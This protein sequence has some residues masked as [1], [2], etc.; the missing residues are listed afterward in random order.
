MKKRSTKNKKRH[1]LLIALFFVLIVFLSWILITAP[2]FH[3]RLGQ[4]WRALTRESKRILGWEKGQIPPEEKRIREEVILKK[5]E[6]ASVHQDWR[7]LAP[8]YPRPKKVE[9]PNAEEKM[10]AL[11]N[12]SEFKEIDK[13]LKEYLKKKEDLFYPEAPAPSLKDATDLISLKDKGTEKVIERLL[14]AKQGNIQEKPLEENLRLGMRGPLVS[15]KIVGRPHPPQVK[16]KVEAEIELTLWVL[17]SGI[18]DRVVLS[19]KGDTELERIA[20]QYLKQ[21]RFAPLPKDQPQEEQ[22]GTVPIK[23]RLQ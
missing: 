10:K 17:P 14:S 22:W 6:E 15:R 7:T 8:E 4:G 13:E 18:V 2:T 19:V 3:F 23:F 5:M 1:F 9:S 21:W 20:I 12:S 11:K 16:V